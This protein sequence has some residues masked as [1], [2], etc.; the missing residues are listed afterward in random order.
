MNVEGQPENFHHQALQSAEDCRR[1][2]NKA[3]YQQKKDLR[4]MP[5]VS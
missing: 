5:R 2:I 4:A 3:L 1:F